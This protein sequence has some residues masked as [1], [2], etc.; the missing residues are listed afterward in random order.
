MTAK[1]KRGDE[2][3]PKPPKP[4]KAARASAQLGPDRKIL[5]AVDFGT[6]FSGLAWAQ[7]RKPEVQTPITQWPDASSGGL[8]GISSDKVPSEMKYDGQNFKWGFQIPDSVQRHQTFKLDLDPSQNRTTALASQYHDP[9]KAPPAYDE[10]A[11]RI[12]TDYM[13]AL[14]KHAE[15]ILRYKLPDSALKSTPVEYIITVPAVWSDTAQ[16]KTR[17][18]AQAA[19]MGVGANLHIISEPEAAALYALDAM[20]PHNLTVGDTFVLCD[21]GGGTVDLITYTVSALRPILKLTEA[22]PGTGSLCGASFLN[23]KFAEMLR[24]KL[25]DQPGWDEEVLEDA[26]KYFESVIKRQFRGTFGEEFLVPV[27]GVLDNAELGIRRNKMT[28]PGTDIR[29][30]FEPVLDE[31]LKLVTGQV[32]ASKSPVKAIVLVG[33]FGQ[34]AYLRDSI[35]QEVKDLKIEVMQS[36]N[37]WTAV[38]RGALMKG[39]AS[40]SP[41]FAKVSIAAR[42]ARKHYGLDVNT[43]FN[44]GEHDYNRRF[45]DACDGFYRISEMDWFVK[46]GD[47]IEENKPFRLRYHR[48]RLHSEG[49]FKIVRDNI[50]VC[51]DRDNLG[52][53]QYNEEGNDVQHLVTIHA[54]LSRVPEHLMPTKRGADGEKYYRI[55][56]EI[57]ITYHSAYTTYELIYNDVNYGAVNAEYV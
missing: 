11:E 16:A 54:D 49:P 45:W 39:L 41:N 35:R 15:Q 44:A 28:I 3:P 34:N 32:K 26:V 25:E 20:D 8:E 48:V 29:A 55:K 27:P 46:K 57:Q 5:V 43:S 21:A 6:T 47:L 2:K 56:Y 14:R 33:G 50:W 31:V 37:S 10:D 4:P 13:G 19:G 7:S 52:A 22:S 24:V 30:A 17:T 51:Q 42:A 38:V 1:R 53:P 23:R 18:C 40:T 12:T 36:P 9:K